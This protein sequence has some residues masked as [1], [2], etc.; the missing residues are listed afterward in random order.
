MLTERPINNLNMDIGVSLLTA[1]ANITVFP[2][3]NWFHR[4]PTHDLRLF[5]VLTDSTMVK[6]RIPKKAKERERAR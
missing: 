3:R 4:L 1:M 6:V 5:I 2:Q